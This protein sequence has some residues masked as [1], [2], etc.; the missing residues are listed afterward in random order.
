MVQML[1]IL[2]IS[3]GM[4]RSADWPNYRG[5]DHN[6]SSQET[7]WQ[8]DWDA[9]EPKIL[10]TKSIGFGFGSVAVADGR[11]YLMGNTGKEGD[12][13]N[14]DI[15]YCVDAESGKEIWRHEYP[16]LLQPRLHEGGPLATPT[17]DGKVVYT[18]SRMGDLFCF[19]AASGE[20]IWQKQLAD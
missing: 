6:G 5:P 1:G 11:A 9:Q 19:N 8:T 18:L 15:V 16:C 12:N 20:I 14:T 17:V 3:G 2:W 13:A 7:D 4:A 10:W